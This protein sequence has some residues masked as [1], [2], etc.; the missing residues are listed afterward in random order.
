MRRVES[1]LRDYADENRRLER[2]N[3]ELRARARWLDIEHVHAL[4]DA[5]D[6]RIAMENVERAFFDAELRLDDV[7]ARLALASPS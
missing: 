4:R 1:L 5:A 6:L 2:E 3:G 7:D